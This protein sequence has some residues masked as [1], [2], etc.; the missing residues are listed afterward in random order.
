MSHALVCSVRC[1]SFCKA[2]ING[3]DRT[4]DQNCTTCTTNKPQTSTRIVKT[5]IMKFLYLL[6]SMP[7]PVL[8][9][10]AHWHRADAFRGVGIGSVLLDDSGA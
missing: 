8:T 5:N 2:P 1:C 6:I 7:G 4:S 3:P 10:L 9:Y